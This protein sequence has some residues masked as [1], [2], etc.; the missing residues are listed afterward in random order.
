MKKILLFSAATALF[1][2]SA[3]ATVTINLGAG[4]LFES[5]GTTPVPNGALIQLIV[6]TGDAI[7]T[8]PTPTSFTG[9]SSDDVVVASFMMNSFGGGPGIFTQVVNFAYSGSL[10]P[11]EQMMLRWWPLISGTSATSPGTGASYGQFRT[12][13]VE[14]S[15]NIA[16]IT[17]SDG[18]NVN[19]FFLTG[20]IGGV[21]PN[22]AGVANLTVVPEPSPFACVGAGLAALVVWQRVRRR[23]G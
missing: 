1:H 16:W 3:Q 7:F 8:A 5:D 13:N 9:G 21:E 23:R 6:S 17:P 15:S 22:S 2:F 18:S 10:A 4:K 19:L 20:T 14:N 11:G 12:D